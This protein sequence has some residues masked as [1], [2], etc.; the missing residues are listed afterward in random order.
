MS[1][2]EI[3]KSSPRSKSPSRSMSPSKSMSI[4]QGCE[5]YASYLRKKMDSEVVQLKAKIENQKAE[6]QKSFR[7]YK[8]LKDK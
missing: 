8:A 7:D 2:S 4:P 5:T 3:S 1:D 6:L